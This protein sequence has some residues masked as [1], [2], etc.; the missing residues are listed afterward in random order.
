MCCVGA[1]NDFYDKIEERTALIFRILSVYMRIFMGFDFG[2]LPQNEKMTL[3]F[4]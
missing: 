3:I 2:F 1:Y 4:H